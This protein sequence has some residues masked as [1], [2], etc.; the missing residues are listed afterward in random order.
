MSFTTGA[1]GA[2]GL[3]EDEQEVP[4]MQSLGAGRQGEH[5]LPFACLCVW[6]RGHGSVQYFCHQGKTGSG[7]EGQ[8]GRAGTAHPP[9]QEQPEGISPAPQ[10]L[11]AVKSC[12]TQLH[13]VPA[14]PSVT[15]GRGD[16]TGTR[17]IRR[18]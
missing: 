5:S 1:P 2:G 12:L 18:F 17:N 7:V 9:V 11:G 16:V 13:P 15:M 4:L 6:V 14:H 8:P 10:G 3:V